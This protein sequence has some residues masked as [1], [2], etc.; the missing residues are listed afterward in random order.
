MDHHPEPPCG[1]QCGRW[2]NGT[3]ADPALRDFDADAESRVAVLTGAGGQFCAGADLKTVALG[4]GHADALAFNT[5]I[6]QDGP[7]GPR[8]IA[9]A[10]ALRNMLHPLDVNAGKLRR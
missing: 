8:D 10:S 2:P 1:A 6:D 4:V 3:I 7:M 5:D 9:P